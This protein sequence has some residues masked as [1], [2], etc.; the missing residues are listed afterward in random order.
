MQKPLTGFLQTSLHG[1]IRFK[2]A[3]AAECELCD[4]VGRDPVHF[5]VAPTAKCKS[6]DLSNIDTHIKWY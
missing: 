6:C 4:L 2:A 5:K 1:P 3:P